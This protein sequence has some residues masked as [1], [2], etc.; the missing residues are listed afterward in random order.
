MRSIIVIVLISA[1]SLTLSQAQAQ[2]RLLKGEVSYIER[3]GNK[4]AASGV[5]VL[6]KPLG[7]SAI[8]DDDGQFSVVLPQAYRPGEPLTFE[9]KEEK[10]RVWEPTGGRARI[11]RNLSKDPIAITLLP[12]GSKKFWTDAFIEMFVEQT[13]EKAK[14]LVRA[15]GKPQEIDFGPMIKEWAANYGFTAQEAKVQIDKWVQETQ[16]KQEDFYKLGLAA[17]AEKNFKRAAEL[18]EEDAQKNAKRFEMKTKE[19]EESRAKAINSFRKAGDSHYSSYQFTKALKSYERAMTYVDKEKAGLLLADLQMEIAGA[20]WAI[21]IR[22]GGQASRKHLHRA[23][24]AY[25]LAASAYTRLHNAEGL[26]A[27]QTGKG[28]VFSQQGIRTGGAEGQRLLGEA[29]AAYRAALE[30][31]TRELLPQD[32]AMTQNNLGTTLNDQGIRTGGAEGQRL[33]GE[34]V[35]A[36]KLA[37][38]VRTRETLPPQWAQ[39]HNNLAEAALALRD[40]EQ[41][42]ASY[43]NVLA[44]YPDYAKAYNIMNA[45][46]HEHLFRYDKAYALNKHW[47]SGHPSDVSGHSNFAESHFTTGRFSEAETRLGELLDHPKLD[48]QAQVVLR[49]IEIGALAAQSKDDDIPE[50]LR[51]LRTRV[52]SSPDEFQLEWSFEGT[53][54][55]IG[56]HEALAASREFLLNLIEGFE[57]KDKTTMLAAVENAQ[58]QFVAAM[59]AGVR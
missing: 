41:V 51:S 8:T 52:E 17:F 1:L 26:A 9:V 15:E 23:F 7:G 39:T 48:A 55:F 2:V 14:L 25:D 57:G 44:L 31:R 54:H 32:W 4:R 42:V 49:I 40:W 46:L 53:K 37:L 47:V 36:F 10:W 43:Q 20:N 12:K 24:S 11:P 50:K 22:A 5:E 33:L 45:V 38:E 16:E 58:S 21:G 34:A 56:Q 29:V 27:A 3:D 6:V 28:I 13:A 35:A 18:F 30:V 19:A 59:G